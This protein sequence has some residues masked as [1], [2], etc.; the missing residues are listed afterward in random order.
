M[1][2]KTKSDRLG[3]EFTSL[4]GK[5]HIKLKQAKMQVSIMPLIILTK[6][7]FRSEVW[8][9][10]EHSPHDLEHAYTY[11]NKVSVEMIPEFQGKFYF[12]IM[13]S[14]KNLQKRQNGNK[15]QRN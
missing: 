14:R 12:H 11:H 9:I 8:A 15:V 4:P 1:K 2:K 5:Y 7:E 3:L 6:N 10:F 13:Q